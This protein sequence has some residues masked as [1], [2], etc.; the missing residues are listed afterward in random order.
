MGKET[1][2]MEMFSMSPDMLDNTFIESIEPIEEIEE[3]NEDVVDTPNLDDD[4]D[5]K[6][7]AEAEESE[8][9]SKEKK[10]EVKDVA[11]KK[12]E[13]SSPAKI[14]SSFAKLLKDKGDIFDT[15]E[16]KED[17]EI[18]S[19]EDLVEKIRESLQKQV[20]AQLDEIQKEFNDAFRIG[21]PKDEFAQIQGVISNL[22]KITDDSI[23]GDTED[24]A[25]L[26]FNLIKNNF[27]LQGIKDDKAEKLAKLSISEQNDVEDAKKA[28]E[29]IKEHYKTE[30]NTKKESY[31]KKADDVKKEETQTLET[32]K[33]KVFETKKIGDFEL[34]EKLQNK[35]FDTATKIVGKTKEGKPLNAYM[36]ARYENPDDVDLKTSWLWTVTKGFKDFSYFVNK[37]KVQS[38]NDFEELL[39]SSSKLDNSFNLGE[40]TFSDLAKNILE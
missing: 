23:E 28:L 38:A 37:G 17:E 9:V 3:L 26:R 25:A 19:A 10:E 1:L 36:K 11:P 16:I 14:Y 12:S 34:D 29:E 21:M 13:A 31:K 24:S 22:N 30:Y 5:I 33:S 8:K 35:V 18:K 7:P 32:F 6:I 40:Q 20:D 15:L 27:I 4:E 2:D 39:K